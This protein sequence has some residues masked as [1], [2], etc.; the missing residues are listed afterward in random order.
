[1]FVDPHAH[2]ISRTTD[3]YE[4]MA[5][6][7]GARADHLTAS[8]GVAGARKTL[9]MPADDLEDVDVEVYRRCCVA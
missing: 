4:A 7:G 5:R 2:M 6:S 8:A 9:D 3:D 1:M